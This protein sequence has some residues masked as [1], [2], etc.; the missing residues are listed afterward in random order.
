M[1]TAGRKAQTIGKYP[2]D[3]MIGKIIRWLL[4]AGCIGLCLWLMMHAMSA[5]ASAT[6]A[7]SPSPAEE[8]STSANAARPM[9][10][11]VFAGF[12]LIGA[13]I[14]IAPDTIGMLCG[15]VGQMFGNV[16]FPEQWNAKPGLSYTLP[17]HYMNEGRFEEAVA[18]YE[19]ILRYY[20][21]EKDAHVE[22]L[23]AAAQCGDT[24]AYNKYAKLLKKRFDCELE[25]VYA[26]EDEAAQ[27]SPALPAEETPPKPPEEDGTRA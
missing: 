12:A 9:P 11:L 6:A 14:L 5:E 10:Y 1:L 3:P 18:E 25:V 7:A 20:P 8:I 2:P 19:K 21:E 24:K 22:L 4:A 16:I 23:T 26:D 13:V 15:A 17:R 27:E